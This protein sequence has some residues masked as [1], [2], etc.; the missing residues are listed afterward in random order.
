MKAFSFFKFYFGVQIVPRYLQKK[1]VYPD[2]FVPMTDH[3]TG[4]EF[5]FGSF[6]YFLFLP[7]IENGV[8]LCIRMYFGFFPPK[9]S[10]H[11]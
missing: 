8:E 1:N 6:F 10:Y 3:R 2:F 11:R 9:M 5:E 4:E 7:T